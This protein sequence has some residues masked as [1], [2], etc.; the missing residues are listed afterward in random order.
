MSTDR[1]E[2]GEALHRLRRQL[3]H[4]QIGGSVTVDATALRIALARIAELERLPAPLPATSS[5]TRE[6][7]IEACAS[8]AYEH[9]HPSPP[10]TK[11][12]DLASGQRLSFIA[13]ATRLLDGHVMEMWIDPDSRAKF[14]RRV[15]IEAARHPI[16][17]T[18]PALRGGS[19]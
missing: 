11:W 12:R 2:L 5:E 7:A 15:L 6:Q 1:T 4:H 17:A 8:L 9:V 19:R 3:A 13:D 16:L 10:W 14:G 18:S